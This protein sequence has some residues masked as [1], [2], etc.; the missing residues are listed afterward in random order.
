MLGDGAAYDIPAIVRVLEW[1]VV[2]SPAFLGPALPIVAAVSGGDG[3][4]QA[5]NGDPV[6]PS[7]IPLVLALRLFGAFEVFGKDT[8]PFI[9]PIADDRATRTAGRKR[10]SAG[11][12]LPD[13]PSATA[14]RDSPLG[15]LRPVPVRASIT[16]QNRSAANQWQK[17]RN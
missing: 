15:C 2:V 8:G 9:E 6:A 14:S 11:V 1:A 7:G 16:I 3:V 5:R 13:H 10:L 17:K 12:N 4:G